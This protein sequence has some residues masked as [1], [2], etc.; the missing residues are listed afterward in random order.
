LAKTLRKGKENISISEEAAAYEM[1]LGL[2]DLRLKQQCGVYEL[3]DGVRSA[4]VKGELNLSTSFVLSEAKKLLRGQKNGQVGA[5]A[6]QPPIVLDF[7]SIARSY[8]MD[9]ADSTRKTVTLD[10]VSKPRHREQSAFLHRLCFL[11]TPFAKR[12]YGPD[13]ESRKDTKLVREKW[14]YAFSGRVN[15][16]LIEKSHLGGTVEEACESQLSGLIKTECHNAAE[17]SHLLVRAG[18]MALF[19]QTAR[20][21]DIVSDAVS[22]DHSF[23]SLAKAIENLSFL[24]G[25]EQILRI[26]QMDRISD[27]IL[28]AFRRAL[29]MIPT[30]TAADEKEDFKLAEI[31]KMLYQVC[32][33]ADTEN[34]EL[35]LE[36]L[37][38][39]IE[40]KN[41]P[42]SV[43]GAAVGLLYQSGNLAV[44]GV[45]GR[46]GAYF[47]ASGDMLA[48]SGRFLRGLF[49]TAKD[50]VFYDD[51][52]LSGLNG[53]LRDFSY[54]AFLEL[55]PDIRL[56][57]TY[58]SPREIFKISEKVLSLFGFD[59]QQKSAADLLSLPVA[60]EKTVREAEKLDQAAYAY[61]KK[62]GYLA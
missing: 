56:S 60:D 28:R 19:S 51:G 12:T 21:T 18:I 53:I 17:A 48:M 10:I 30:L 13:Y 26:E 29:V 42:P 25:I 1:G 58:F 49:L 6:P 54:E 59:Q 45:L 62:R 41:C 16:A 22:E 11:E 46:A 14:D 3:L 43:E 55:L 23:V 61:L 7:E 2:A 33:L 8:R 31:L 52:F 15:A 47:S 36:S 5:D 50:V 57:F 4:F 37:A 9:I 39:L 44:D 34:R 20:L 32:A 27:M 24:R 35:Y 38:D 40:Q